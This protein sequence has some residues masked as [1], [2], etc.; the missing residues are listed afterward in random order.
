MSARTINLERF[1]LSPT[2]HPVHIPRWVRVR[3]YK[4]F[5]RVRTE[6]YEGK[7]SLLCYPQM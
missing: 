7:A 4:D 6:R 3:P 5:V 1:M 2:A